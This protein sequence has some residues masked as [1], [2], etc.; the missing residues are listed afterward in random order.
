MNTIAISPDG[1][2]VISGS[3]DETLRVWDLAS[4][5]CLRTLHGHTDSVNTIAITADGRQ[6]VSGSGDKTL[7]VWDLESCKCLCTL[8]GH[9]DSVNAIAITP[10]GR[11]I[12]SGGKDK[13]LCVWD[14]DWDY[15]FP[16]SVDWDK[17]ARP[18]LEIFLTLHTPYDPDGFTRKGKPVWTEADFQDLLK[19]LGPRGF[20]WLRS[21]VV[22]RKLEEMAQ[23]RG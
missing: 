7:K 1:R 14:L 3:T 19:S 13:T 17:A 15:E 4:G 18:Y 2:Q 9:T 12:V 6:V 8:E 10:D 22:R 23:E 16:D 5:E 11:Q 21:E 20:G